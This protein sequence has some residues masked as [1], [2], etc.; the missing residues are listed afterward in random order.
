MISPRLPK[1]F[2]RWFSRAAVGLLATLVWGQAPARAQVI[3][4]SFTTVQSTLSAPPDA[5]S[6]ATGGADIVGTKRGIVQHEVAG[7]GPST[8]AVAAGLLTLTVPNTTPDS[9]AEA[10][11]SWDGDNSPAVLNPTGLGAV[12][13]TAGN[14]GGFRIRVASAGAGAELEFAVYSTAANFSRAARLLPAIASS[15]DVFLSFSEFRTA[16]GTGANFASVGAIELTVR[17]KEIA[18]VLD[19]IVTSAPILAATKVDAQTVDVDGDTRVDPGDR[20]RYTVTITNTGNDALAVD[21]TDAVDANTTLVAGSVHSTPVAR[22]DQY[23]WFGNVTFAADGSAGRPGLLANDEDGDGDTLTVTSVSPTSSQ[24]GTVTLDD[25]A[26][27]KFT[28]APPA[29]FAGVDSFGYTLQDD[30]GNSKSATAYVQLKGIVWFV[31]N[32]C[33]VGCGQGTFSSPFTTLP[34]AETASGAND[35]VYV[36]TGS[37]AYDTGAANGF[38]MDADEQLLGEGVALVLDGTTIVPVG[39]PPLLTNEVATVGRGV[40]LA[41]SGTDTLRGLTIGN[42]AGA[43]IFG[44]TFGTL[45][46]DTLTLN[47]TGQALDLTNGVLATTLVGLASSTSATTGISLATVSGSLTVTGSTGITNPAGTGISIATSTA[48]LSFASTSIDK[49]ASAGTGLSITGSS[50]TTGFSNLAVTTSAGT[51]VLVSGSPL[52]V[53]GSASTIAATGG[54]ALD[55]T[56][57]NLGAG[58]T[59][60]TASSTGSAGKGMNLDTLT[61]ALTMNGG[62]ISTPTGTA[63]DLNAG[64]ANVTYAG[65]VSNTANAL[66]VEI[67]GRSGGTVA[68][69]GAL[70]S[71]GS[72]NGISVAN[73]TGGTINFSNASKTLTTGADPAVT[74]ASNTGATINFS[75]G[76]LA[77]TTT[78]GAGFTATGG[79]TAITVQGTANTISSTT[80]TALNVANSTI[81]ASGLTFQSVS[82]NG[83]SR[84]IVLNTTG[85]SGGLTVTGNGGTCTSADTSG[86]S[87]GTIQASTGADDSSLTP[88]GTGI[89]LNSTASVSLTRMFIHDHSNY[90]IRGTSVAGFTL[91][92]SVLGGTNGGPLPASAGSPFHDGSIKFDNLTGSATIS[93]SAISGGFSNNVRVDNTTGTLNRITFSGDTIGANSTSDGEDGILLETEGSGGVILAT[94]QNCAFTSA[95]GDLFN[96]VSNSTSATADDLVFTGNTLTNNHPAIA[97]GGGGTTI[98]SNGGKTFTFSMSGNSFRDAVGIGVLVVK[99]TGSSTLSGT[100][101]NN[102]IGVAAVANS[103][104]LEGSAIKVQNAGLGAVTMAITNNQIRQYNNFES[105]SRPGAAPHP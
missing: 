18:V 14:S 51:G 102:S 2:R 96:F 13:L 64:S 52:S 65:S 105:S 41:A 82:A 98:S 71:T 93:N 77:I 43:K 16:G 44:N 88:A 92:Q 72:G 70:S 74:L 81:G 36:R 33:S 48:A 75:G 7:A 21:L 103:G 83:A 30:D 6:T 91:D 22:N 94:V 76:G 101:A 66:L 80:G 45:A 9:R 46:T 62:S 59:F 5:S 40:T 54:P 87:G 79:A 56:T 100:F 29:G 27:G 35:I 61:G 3:V 63:F 78:S 68:L 23:G 84:G 8:V 11:L 20:V 12:N 53:G 50:G 10:R 4:D 58:A 99:S 1:R 89:V 69:S 38:S 25:A 31:D 97:T 47:G 73:N 104:S 57:V 90:G 26:T 34:Q 86:C 39:A 49:S 17:G 32:A 60:A 28:Y 15:T 37:G 85:A 95:R 55:L 24:G 19:E 42:T 67:T